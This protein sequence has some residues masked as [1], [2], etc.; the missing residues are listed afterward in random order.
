[1]GHH[2]CIDQ[3]LIVALRHLLVEWQA[4]MQV[5]SVPTGVLIVLVQ[6]VMCEPLP[7]LASILVAAGD[8]RIADLPLFALSVVECLVGQVASGSV[9]WPVVLQLASL[10]LGTLARVHRLLCGE[11]DLVAIVPVGVKRVRF[12]ALDAFH[13]EQII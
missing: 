7:P 11:H 6:L 3:L 12:L 9:E 2:L 8:A 13:A 4:S 1:M 10:S 5:L